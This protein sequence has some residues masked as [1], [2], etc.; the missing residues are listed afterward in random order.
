[1]K[2]AV[3]EKRWD[4]EK[5]SGNIKIQQ[6]SNLGGVLVT[7]LYPFG[8]QRIVFSTFDQNFYFKIIR[9]HQ[10]NYYERR[11]YESVAYFGLYPINLRKAELLVSK[12]YTICISVGFRRL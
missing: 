11:A 5:L 7:T 12:G 2:A 9:D 4:A 6:Q 10:K 3:R 1:M 8:S